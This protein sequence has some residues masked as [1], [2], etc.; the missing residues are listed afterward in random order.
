MGWTRTRDRWYVCVSRR[1]IADEENKRICRHYTYGHEYDG[2][3]K[4]M[5]VV[6]T[7][8]CPHPILYFPHVQTFNDDIYVNSSSSIIFNGRTSVLCWWR[9]KTRW[10]AQLSPP[11]LLCCC[12]NF[13]FFRQLKYLGREMFT[14]H[15]ITF[16]VKYFILKNYNFLERARAWLRLLAKPR[17]GFSPLTLYPTCR[18]AK[19]SC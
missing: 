9:C 7:S 5:G 11:E 16:S 12:S 3:S 17:A 18:W 8:P 13:L 10:G 1:E 19:Y 2:S 15:F 4:V 14:K 6:C